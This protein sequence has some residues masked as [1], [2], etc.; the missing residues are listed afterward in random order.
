MRFNTNKVWSWLSVTH[1]VA[2]SNDSFYKSPQAVVIIEFME[3]Y[4]K[5]MG[6]KI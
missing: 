6:M 4:L 5:V 2:S 1:R 3:T